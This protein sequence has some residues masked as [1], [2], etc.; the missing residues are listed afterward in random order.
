MATT[1]MTVKIQPN[2]KA[3]PPGKLADAE[4]HFT[5]GPR[6]GLK[7]IGFAVWERRGGSVRNVTFPARQY[8]V[9]GEQRIAPPD[10]RHSGAGQD[11]RPRARSVRR[12]RGGS[13]N[14]RII[15]P[16]GAPSRALRLISSV[17]YRQDRPIVGRVSHCV[18]RGYCSTRLLP[19]PGHAGRKFKVVAI[20]F[21][22]TSLKENR[23]CAALAH[24][25]SAS[26]SSTDARSA[27]I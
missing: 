27:G 1:Q 22:S 16:A 12:L 8:S 2:D 21:E 7:L 14:Q 11:S 13:R 17:A 18:R 19:G 9:N 24:G 23:G 15:S 25:V 3:N 26:R 6:E 10:L 5:D 4:L 20:R